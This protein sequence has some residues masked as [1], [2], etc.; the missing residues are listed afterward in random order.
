MNR[1]TEGADQIRTTLQTNQILESAESCERRAHDAFEKVSDIASRI[2]TSNSDTLLPELKRGDA[3]LRKEVEGIAD[4]KNLSTELCIGA[5]RRISV[6]N[7]DLVQLPGIMSTLQADFRAKNNFAHI[8]RLHNMLYTYGATLIEIVRRKEFSRFFYQR[9]QTILEVMAKLTSAERR[10]RQIYRGDVH[11]QLPFDARGLDDSVP[12]IDFSPSGGRDMDEDQE[13]ALERTDVDAFMQI[14]NELNRAL[15]AD[16]RTA[17]HS[18]DETRMALDKLI[19][20]MNGIESSFDKVVERTCEPLLLT[21]AINTNH[22]F[23]ALIFTDVTV[24]T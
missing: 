11:G 23:S 4:T 6:L 22:S 2:N 1:L 21:C 17:V 18:L 15:Q 24:Q 12:S 14:L 19:G 16:P 9:A 10:R 8:Q 13:Y 20:R 7:A 3:L 5:L